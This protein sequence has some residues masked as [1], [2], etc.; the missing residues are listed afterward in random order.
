MTI[1]ITGVAGMIGSRLADWI[2]ENHPEVEII[3]IDNLSTGFI[4]NVNNKV[5]FYNLDLSSNSIEKCFLNHNIDYVY[6]FAAFAAEGL[7]P[8]LRDFNYRNNLLSTANVINNCI[9]YNVKRLVYTSSMGVYGNGTP[10]FDES[11]IPLPIDP[12]GVAK[13]AC[14]MDIKIAGEQHGLDWCIVRPHN[15]YGP[16]QNIWDK[17]RNVLGIWMYEHLNNNPMS[18]YG[19]GD[20]KRAFTY[21]DDC[22]LP[23][24]F[25]SQL[26]T[27][28]KEIINMGASK[29]YTIN[30]ANKILR[31]IINGG[32]VIYKEKRYEVKNA[33]TTYEK[34]IY[35]LNYSDSTSLYDGLKIMWDWAQKQPNRKRFEWQDFELD[36]GLYNFWNPKQNNK[37][38]TRIRIHNPCNE[39]TMH[40]RF[41]NDFWDEF[42]QYLKKFFIVEENRYYEE[43]HS[44]RYRVNYRYGTTENYELLECE[45]AIENLKNGEIVIMSVSDDI[46]SGVIN[47]KA[48]PKFKKALL[49][50]YIRSNVLYHIGQ[51]AYKYSPWTYF[52]AKKFNLEPYYQKRMLSLPKDERLYFKGT[53]LDDRTILNYIDKNIIT[54]FNPVPMDS[55]FDEIINHK[56]ALSVDGRGE[57][58]YR[59][60]ECFAIGVPILRFEYV[61]EMHDPLIPNYH[62]ISIPRPSDMVLYR[63]GNANHAKLIEQR[64]YEVLNDDDFLKF[65]AQ[66]ARKYYEKNC[67]MNVILKNTY[68]L[69]KL[70]EWQ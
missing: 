5:Y 6:H 67:T 43:A 10:P 64:Y 33:H 54:S 21:V 59:D 45:Y 55:Y 30:E 17:Y 60:I 31:E 46:T 53:S 26:D 68:N 62:Y 9:K 4:E 58:C 57:L 65:I 37:P 48:N 13:Y 22:L 35:L 63:T 66:N 61:S 3:G 1:L 34:S 28:S 52:V 36:K 2:I 8:F 18:I 47:E 40:N 70:Y 50:Q 56:I 51:Y 29:H 27:C 14:E 11:H 15:V 12:Y 49:A 42:T 20:Q 16:K 69:L 23:L 32:S 44:T 7:S 39:Y 25:A 41:Y 24:W 19:D 38:M